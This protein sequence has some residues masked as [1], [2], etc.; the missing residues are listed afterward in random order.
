MAVV[1]PSGD[2]LSARGVSDKGL[3]ALISDSLS[4]FQIFQIL[5]SPMETILVPSGVHTAL[6]TPEVWAYADTINFEESFSSAQTRRVW[7][8]PAPNN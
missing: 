4:A 5:S 8:T 3:N 7:S 2:K 1:K 6:V